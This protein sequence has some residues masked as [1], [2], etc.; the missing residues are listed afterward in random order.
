MFGTELSSTVRLLCLLGSAV[1]NT[2]YGVPLWRRP[3]GNC[4]S[5]KWRGT[6]SDRD[7]NI[8]GVFTVDY[9]NRSKIYT[10]LI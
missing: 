7:R 4:R 8:E 6:L 1:S 9:Y 2:V 5:V 3:P 10:L